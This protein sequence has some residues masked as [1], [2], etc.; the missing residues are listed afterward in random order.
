MRNYDYLDDETLKRR[1]LKKWTI[2]AIVLLIAATLAGV[3]LTDITVKGNTRY[4]KEELEEMIFPT[5]PDKNTLYCFLKDKLR[6]HKELPFIEDYDIQLTGPFSA[7][8]II[9]EKSIIGYVRYMSSNMY[10]D[11]EGIVVESSSQM[12][13]DV[14]EITGLS[15]GHIVLNRELPIADNALFNEIM[16]ITQQLNYYGIGASRIDFDSLGNVTVSVKGGDIEVKMGSTAD[17]DSKISVLN[18]MLPKL[19]GLKGTL[20][21]ENYSDADEGGIYTFEKRKEE[22]SDSEN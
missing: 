15:F 16:N 10:F 22:T 13:E 5:Y 18:D 17:I 14:P 12:I 21:I 11:R 4:S 1:K 7:D 6:P 2:L 20:H 3:R 19:E 9:Y 8:L